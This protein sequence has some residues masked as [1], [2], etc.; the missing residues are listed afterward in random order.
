MTFFYVLGA[1]LA[2][3]LFAPSVWRR[4]TPFV[5]LLLLAW[6]TNI[7][8]VAR[9]ISAFDEPA[10]GLYTPTYLFCIISMVLVL[11]SIARSLASV[12]AKPGRPI[13]KPPSIPARPVCPL[14]S[15]SGNS[16]NSVPGV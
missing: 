10:G 15:R 11:D 5:L 2:L 6:I 12:S 13:L 9:G 1:I 16:M 14:L 3:G 4:N 8:V 7:V